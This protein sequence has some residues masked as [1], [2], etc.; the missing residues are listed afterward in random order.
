MGEVGGS[1]KYKVG[2]YALASIKL[3][4]GWSLT[5]DTRWTIRALAYKASASSSR[6]IQSLTAGS[7]S[8]SHI[9][10]STQSRNSFSAAPLSSA[11][12][13]CGCTPFFLG[14]LHVG[15]LQ[16]LACLIQL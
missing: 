6:L 8:M 9:Y 16:Q 11:S 7:V 1:N 4:I 14:A 3:R 5:H 2:L 13:L 15:P 10:F 12:N